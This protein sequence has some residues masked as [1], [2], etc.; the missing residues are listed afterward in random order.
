MSDAVC[1][2]ET[3]RGP[4]LES[5]HFGHAVIARADGE[6]V[7][8][9]GNPQKLV[10]P[11]SSHKM[12]QALPLVESGAAQGLTSE[13]LAL[14]CASHSAEEIHVS[15]VSKWLHDLG[16]G[17]HSLCC[18]PTPSLDPERRHQMIR[19]G[20][21]HT[22]LH[23]DCSGK[24]AGFLTLTR[25]LGAEERYVDPTHP[26]QLAVRRAIEEMAGE[27]SLGFG[28]D[29]CSAPNFAL[30]LEGMARAMAKFA[31]MGK[32][33]S[34]RDAACTALRDAMMRHPELVSGTRRSCNDLMRA[35]KGKA[36]VKSGAE[37]FYVA[38]LPEAQLGIALKIEDGAMRA[39]AAAM[40]ALLVRTGAIDAD[41]AG[42][43]AYLN[44]PIRSF[45]DELV[46]TIRPASTLLS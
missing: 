6:I 29:G 21:A 28:I 43:E 11:R 32:G 18:G 38:I 30:S 46:G 2:V 20:E 41:A 37:G 1:L 36:A 44:G 12:L 17:E 8:A 39:S 24:H 34:A 15:R 14:A 35:A 7:A 9:W 10:L 42:L 27:E 16:Y 26:V 23:S 33:G 3:T 4:F 40:A 45:N 31:T 19:D 25:H 13:H 5:R 22:R